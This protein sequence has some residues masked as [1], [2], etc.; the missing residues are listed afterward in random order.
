MA[1]A[2]HEVVEGA[3]G[4]GAEASGAF[5]PFDPT[6]F[7]S[8]LFWFA[9]TFGALYFVLSRFALP[10]VGAVLATRAGKITGDLEAA[11][12]ESAAADAARIGAEQAT[13][14]ARN[15]ARTLIEAQ[16]A[17]V[18]A[19]LAGEQA[20]AEAA[21]SERTAKAEAAI[22]Q[23]RANALADVDKVA[24]DLARDIVGRIMPRAAAEPAPKRRVGQGEAI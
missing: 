11:A 22:A 7:A 21:L 20:K 9:L 4:H 3:A 6:L 12:R 19:E 8:Q 1:D 15:D 10:K 14:K 2:P 13:A 17:A 18:T 5:P 24:A 16:R 23:T